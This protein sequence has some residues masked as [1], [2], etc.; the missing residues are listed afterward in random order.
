MA[1]PDKI[2]GAETTIRE[3]EHFFEVRDP[4]LGDYAL[5]RADRSINN[6]IA[7]VITTPLGQRAL[8]ITQLS[9]AEAH[10]TIPG[11][12]RFHRLGHVTALA[13]MIQRFARKENVDEDKTLAYVLQAA[14]SD[15]AHGP[16]SHATD[17]AVEG[18]GNSETYHES[19]VA[20]AFELGGVNSVFK[21]HNVTVN[22]RGE[23]EGVEIPLWV[24]SKAPDMCVDRLQYTL[25][26]M[27]LWFDGSLSPEAAKIRQQ[28]VDIAKLDSIEID[29]Q[30]RMVFTDIDQARLLA[31]GYLL[32]STEHW[33]DPVNRV[34]LY[35]LI[36]SLKYSILNRRLPGMDQMDNGK[37][38]KPH[39]YLYAIDSDV[40]AAM[41][42]EPGKTDPYLFATEGQLADI[43]R[44]EQRRFTQFKR[45]TYERF[46]VDASAEEYPSFILNPG[47][48]DFGPPSSRF[49][50]E[51]LD[52]EEPK[53]PKGINPQVPQLMGENGNLHYRLNPLKNRRID[54]LVKVGDDQLRLSEVDKQYAA[55]LEQHQR[56]QRSVLR[57]HVPTTASYKALLWRQAEEVTNNFRA[58]Q[59]TNDPLNKDPKRRSIEAAAVRARGKAILRGQYVDLR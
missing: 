46:L 31:K 40:L 26:E 20:E 37:T 53:V 15:L 42:S 32:L 5:A 55:L 33:N 30:G 12:H 19:R 16:F 48:V 35:L 22:E 25:H 56:I 59:E 57:V 28:L 24:E 47:L 58:A 6:L 18:T 17:I 43:G 13:E 7:D 4:L 54:P 23:I 45:P 44:E 2:Q 41:E 29:D 34:Q 14:P 21:K 8:D 9:K 38:R 39:D 11:T 10:A 50:I 52:E 1:H 36:E 51:R 27:L 49:E 3:G